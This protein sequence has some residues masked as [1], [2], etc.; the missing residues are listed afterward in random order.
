MSETGGSFLAEAAAEQEDG[1]PAAGARENAAAAPVDGAQEA[2]NG[3]IDGPPEWAPKKYWDA[4]KKSVNVEE[5]SKGYSN[6]EKLLGREKVPVPTDE[7]DQD[8]WDRWFKASGRPESPDKYQFKEPELPE[9]LPYDKEA[10]ANF[11]TW[12]HLNG[13]NQKQANNLYDGYVKTQLERHVAWHNDQ[14]QRRQ[15]LEHNLQR[16]FGNRL[17]AVKQR[18]GLVVRE[19]ADPEFH[20]FLNES[21]LGNDPRMIRFMAKVGEKLT[22]ETKLQGRAQPAAQPQDYDRA[23]ADFRDKHKEALFDANHPNHAVRVKEFNKLFE[24]AY[25]TEPFQR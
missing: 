16:E 23:I 3:V 8:G 14:K 1:T 11:R 10:E 22:G 2:I 12:A 13:L 15:E 21:G 7:E 9:D 19:N 24:G 20:Q 5:L 6:L 17:D 4:E 25:G 18:A